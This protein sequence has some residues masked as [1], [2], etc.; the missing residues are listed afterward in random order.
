[1]DDEKQL[2]D[3]PLVSV[4][5]P[6]YNAEVFI[7]RTLDSVLSQTYKNLEVLVIDDG[8]GDQTPEIVKSF[9]QKDPRVILLQ[10]PNSG[11]AAARNLGIENSRGEF[12][13][14]IDA[15]DIWYPENIEKQVQRIIEIGEN[16]GLVYSWSVDIDK[17]DIPTG[18]FRASK[19][20]GEVYKTLVC[21]NFIGNASAS[22]IRR[23]CLDKIGGY[24]CQLRKQNAQ[25]CEDWELYLRI[26]KYYQFLVVPEFLI[27]YRKTVESM[28]GDYSQMAKSHSL[29]LQSVKQNYPELP[30]VLCHLSSS[31]FYMYL[32]HQS[33]VTRNHKSTLYWLYQAI[34]ADFITPFF[35]YGFYILSIKSILGLIVEWVT[36]VIKPSQDTLGDSQILYNSNQP[37]ISIS[38]LNQQKL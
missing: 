28:S 17:K 18:N 3:L 11:V 5:I 38:T 12:I 19:I 2:A 1:M 6:A 30:T 32:A 21:H 25:G 37:Q 27:G 34:K 31:S 33:S 23:T 26:A 10:Q 29:M 7:E 36:S 35:R 22:L 8:S 13:A 9:A 15:D 14:P 4:I 20:E 24:N 16:V